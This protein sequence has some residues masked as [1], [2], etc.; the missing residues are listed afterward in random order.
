MSRYYAADL[1]ALQSATARLLWAGP[2]QQP[3]GDPLAV[4]VARDTVVASISASV[5]ALTHPHPRR[6]R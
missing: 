3:G 4:L 2:P 5:H 6:R 1:A